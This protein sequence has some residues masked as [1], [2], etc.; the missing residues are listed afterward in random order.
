MRRDVPFARRRCPPV[1][2][3]VESGDDTV[4]GRHTHGSQQSAKEAGPGTTLAGD[5][6][7]RRGPRVATHGGN[8]IG[9]MRI[10]GSGRS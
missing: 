4:S 5:C 9:V 8:A 1:S 10:A 2:A 3:G 6:C 7:Q